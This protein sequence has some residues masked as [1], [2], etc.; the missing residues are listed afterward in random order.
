MSGENTLT[1]VTGKEDKAF[2]FIIVCNVF[3]FF[4]LKMMPKWEKF[5]YTKYILQK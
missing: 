5:R 2:Y 4:I 3:P 1:Y